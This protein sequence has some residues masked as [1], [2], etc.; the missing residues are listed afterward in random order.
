MQNSLHKSKD[1]DTAQFNASPRRV[2]NTC[3]TLTRDNHDIMVLVALVHHVVLA[4]TGFAV[5]YLRLMDPVQHE[6]RGL[7][8]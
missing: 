4:V 8:L 7:Q 3:G 5:V 2:P 1:P 6:I